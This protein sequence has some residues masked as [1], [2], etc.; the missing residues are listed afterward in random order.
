MTD[1]CVRCGL[2]HRPALTGSD[3]GDCWAPP[4]ELAAERT[5]HAAELAEAQEGLHRCRTLLSAMLAASQ[6][7][8]PYAFESLL[9][10]IR[11]ELNR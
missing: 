8:E 10:S 4:P 9:E 1:A 2:I 11:T 6:A 7:F 5:A 3:P